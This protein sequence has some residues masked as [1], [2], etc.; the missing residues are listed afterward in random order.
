MIKIYFI[1][2]EEKHVD[3]LLLELP[4]VIRKK[5]LSYKIFNK[6]KEYTYS[7]W[8]RYFVLSNILSC[9][10]NDLV[11]ENNI[12]GRPFLKNLDRFDFN[13][14]HTSNCIVLAVTFRNKIGIDIENNLKK[15]SILG[16]AEKYFSSNDYKWLSSLPSASLNYW[17]YK[18]WT[19]KEACVKMIGG[20]IISGLKDI[21]FV[22]S[23]RTDKN[24]FNSF[25][26]NYK[27]FEFDNRY[28]LCIATKNNLSSSIDVYKIFL[29]KSINSKKL[30]PHINDISNFFYRNF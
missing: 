10:F 20:N 14:S 15:V 19:Y 13:I 12:N 29:K 2:S 7:Q 6:K 27:H 24:N 23:L 11:F 22:Q 25:S 21:E 16:I 28:T 4:D 5:A 18:I 9:E 3:S 26:F 1:K 8:I 17:F 30:I